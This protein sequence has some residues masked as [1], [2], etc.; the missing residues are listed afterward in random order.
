MADSANFCRNVFNGNDNK[1]IE[2]D[3]N[4]VSPTLFAIAMLYFTTAF[5]NI[6]WIKRQENIAKQS[7]ED[8]GMFSL[9]YIPNYFIII[10]SLCCRYCCCS[11]GNIPGICICLMGECCGQYLHRYYR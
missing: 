5:L 8:E 2:L 10:F 11:F 9:Q 7:N 4:N 3:T 1:G 6:Y